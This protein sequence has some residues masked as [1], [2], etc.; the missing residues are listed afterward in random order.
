MI[1]P[2]THLSQNAIKPLEELGFCLFWDFEPSIVPLWRY[3][4][5]LE[6]LLRRGI[7]S[8]ESF[9]IKE[10]VQ[11]SLWAL[12]F[13][14]LPDG[15][16]TN[17]H[18]HSLFQLRFQGFGVFVVV[19]TKDVRCVPAELTDLADAVYW[20]ALPGY[21]FSAYKLG[22]S[23]L[24]RRSEGATVLVMNDSVLGPICDVV[25]LTTQAPWDLTGFTASGR[26]ENHIQ[27]YAFVL[28]NLTLDRLRRLRYVLFPFIACGGRDD[29]ITCQESRMARVA[30]GSMS[31]GAY[32]YLP[33]GDPTQIAPFELMEAGYPFIKRSLIE[34][35]SPFADK[36]RARAFFQEIMSSVFS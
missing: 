10:V 6:A 32:W 33:D 25:H 3:R 17:A 12:Y 24:A 26:I 28:N 27:S 30:S 2:S 31:V 18:R 1:S 19:A 35:R 16:L 22:L 8:P 20:K 23:V 13:I 36:E 7:R 15:K 14:Y 34:F 11:R 21:D 5:V 29:V 4:Q 9:P